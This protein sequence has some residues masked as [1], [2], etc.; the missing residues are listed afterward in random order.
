M[1]TLTAN[2]APGAGPTQALEQIKIP[3][4]FVCLS[5]AASTATNPNPNPFR[6]EVAER[7]SDK[8]PPGSAQS[9]GILKATQEWL[10]GCR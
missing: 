3:T 8:V 1:V 5:P 9:L 7:L 4:L 6:P 2:W 10:C